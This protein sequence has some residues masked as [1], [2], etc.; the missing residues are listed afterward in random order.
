M[1]SL[2]HPYRPRVDDHPNN[3]S[4]LISRLRLRPFSSFYSSCSTSSTIMN[5]SW[6]GL[7]VDV[8]YGE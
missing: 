2:F 6:A 1:N 7:S 4:E 8:E 5:V 3:Q